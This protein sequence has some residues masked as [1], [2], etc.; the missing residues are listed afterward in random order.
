M[1]G[2]RVAAA[3]RVTLRTTE[4]DDVPFLTRQNVPDLRLPTGNPI[5]SRASLETWVEEGFGDTT[6]LTVCLEGDT[7]VPGDADEA[8]VQRIGAVT[9]EDHG[10]SRPELAYWLLPSVQGEGYGSEAVGLSVDIV[11]QE[12][13]HPSVE[14]RTFPD[15]DASR[16][17][18]E[19]LGFTQEGR[20]RDA[21]YWN[22][23]YRDRVIY[24]LRRAD[25]DD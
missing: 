16:G 1:P 25:R 13:H 11:F 22:G 17:V 15:N 20:V 3:D 8:D 4:R 10:R 19:S 7:A 18:L 9:I 5:F 23:A 2:P 6:A 12:H 21:V 14:A 24:G